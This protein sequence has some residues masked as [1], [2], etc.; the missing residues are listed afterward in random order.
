MGLKGKGIEIP[1]ELE[2][3]SELSGFAWEARYPG[4]EEPLTEEE[5][6]QAMALAER[7]V[8]WAEKMVANL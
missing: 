7:V 8:A 3:A 6:R 4:T 2:E 5:Y 1:A